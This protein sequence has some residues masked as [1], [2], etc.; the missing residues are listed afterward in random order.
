[1]QIAIDT[2]NQ[3][4]LTHNRYR[5]TAAIEIFLDPLIAVS[6]LIVNAIVFDQALN[7]PHIILALITLSMTFPGSL[8]L[9]DSPGRMVSKTTL[10]W[11]VVILMLLLLGHFTG[12]LSNFSSAFIAGWALTTPVCLLASHELVRRALPKLITRAYQRTAVIV[13]KN[14]IGTALA[15]KFTDDRYAGI[16]FHGFFDQHDSQPA[17][18]AAHQRL[19]GPL[20]GLADYVRRQRIDHIYIALPMSAEPHIRSLLDQIKD[21]T[22]SIYFV[23]DIFLIDLIQGHIDSIGGIPVIAVCET[24]FAGLQG[25]VKRTADV[26]LA[27]VILLLVSPLMVAV[28]LGIRLTS[29]GPIIFAQRRYGLDGREIFVYKFRSMRVT[30]DGDHCYLQVVPGDSRVTRFGAFIRKTSLDELPQFINVLQGRMSV[31]GPRPHAIAVN[32]QYRKLIPGY[33]V[34]HKVKPGITGWAQVNGFR[35]GDDLDHMKSRIKFDLDY[36]RNWSLR[37]DLLIILKTITLV[38]KDSRAY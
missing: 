11:M 30:E 8:R 20:D 21:T 2:H 33:M 5:L 32:E 36:L 28:A 22:A 15:Q 7:A 27:S 25:V 35:G 37:L 9:I 23:P 26:I 12:Y 17:S 3:D 16:R 34:R 29:P 1:M 31:V 24:P 13:G 14:E 38:I 18:Q 19:L 4:D 6:S 10:E